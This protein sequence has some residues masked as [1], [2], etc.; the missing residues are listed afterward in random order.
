M[1]F[2]YQPI[3]TRYPTVM[4][5]MEKRFGLRDDDTSHQIDQLHNVYEES[6][7]STS[8]VPDHSSAIISQVSSMSGASVPVDRQ[9]EDDEFAYPKLTHFAKRALSSLYNS[10]D[11]TKEMLW[12][13]FIAYDNCLTEKIRIAEKQIRASEEEME[14]CKE[15]TEFANYLEEIGGCSDTLLQFQAAADKI[16]S[17][18]N[19][20][21]QGEVTTEHR[22]ED[23]SQQRSTGERKRGDIHNPFAHT[24][25]NVQISVPKNK[26]RYWR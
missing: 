4:E 14:L 9:E 8:C 3:T 21:R 6:M 1:H 25:V 19:R 11:T 2:N 23:P 24:S 13:D 15:E 5:L 26:K 7:I 16:R 22:R 17:E 18:I 20:V 10:S 12:N